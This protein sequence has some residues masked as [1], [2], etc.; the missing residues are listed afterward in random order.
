MICSFY[1][2]TA[3][4]FFAHKGNKQLFAGIV[5]WQCVVFAERDLCVRCGSGCFLKI[6]IL[7]E[8]LVRTKA[9]SISLFILTWESIDFYFG[10]Y[11]W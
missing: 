7:L 4:L 1:E 2:Q 3:C 6:R 8:A 10:E 11:L 9:S 5:I